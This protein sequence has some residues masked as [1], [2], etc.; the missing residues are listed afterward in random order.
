MKKITI[1]ITEKLKINKDSQSKFNPDDMDSHDRF[2]YSDINPDKAEEGDHLIGTWIDIINDNA[3]GFIVF[4]FSSITDSKDLDK[5]FYLVEERFPNVI[6]KV[7]TGHDAGYEIKAKNGHIEIHCVNS[8]SRGIYYIYGLTKN[9]FR[10][11][12]DYWDDNDGATLDFLFNEKNLTP[13]Y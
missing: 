3:E 6:K 7:M 9:G 8:G 10:Y 13:L 1:Y 12:K 4:Q 5:S 2:I 11:A